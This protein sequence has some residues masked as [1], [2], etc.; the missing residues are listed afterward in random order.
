MILSATNGER[1]DVLCMH[2]VAYP[3]AVVSEI[4]EEGI[5]MTAR[6]AS[7]ARNACDVG[8]CRRDLSVIAAV[9]RRGAG[10]ERGAVPD[11]DQRL[12]RSR[13]TA[14][15]RTRAG[16]VTAAEW[17]NLIA[18]DDR[19]LGVKDPGP[20]KQ[21]EEVS[22]EIA[23]LRGIVPSSKLSVSDAARTAEFKG[24]VSKAKTG[25]H[26]VP[27]NFD[28]RA[29]RNPGSAAFRPH[30]LLRSRQ[31]GLQLRRERIWHPSTRHSAP[32]LNRE[33]HERAVR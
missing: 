10:D 16:G 28:H 3:F 9:R 19:H 32:S 1:L 2:G 13:I 18:I 26:Q 14:V 5:R 15:G 30:G 25:H 6:P 17:A 21:C 7:L 22:V 31:Q 33:D 23:P 12:L 20:P 24:R 4:S 8:D 11:H 29:A 27:E